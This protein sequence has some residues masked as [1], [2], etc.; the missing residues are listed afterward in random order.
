MADL[1]PMA[2]IQRRSLLRAIHPSLTWP[3]GQKYVGE[4]QDDKFHGQGIVV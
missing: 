2:G 4:F 3:D 1:N